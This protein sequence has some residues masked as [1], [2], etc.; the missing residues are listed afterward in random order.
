MWVF[1]LSLVLTISQKEIMFSPYL[2][3]IVFLVSTI[4]SAYNSSF[5]FRGTLVFGVESCI[6]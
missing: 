3:S 5:F 1:Y 2:I 4:L 6:F